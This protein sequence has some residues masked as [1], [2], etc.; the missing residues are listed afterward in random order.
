[1]VKDVV[2]PV[3]LGE[4]N[5]STMNIHL[6]RDGYTDYWADKVEI[7]RVLMALV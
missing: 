5:A 4:D 2:V 7:E 3:L 1:M 6:L